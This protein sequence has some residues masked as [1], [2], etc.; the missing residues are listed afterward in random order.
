MQAEKYRPLRIPSL[1]VV[2]ALSARMSLRWS[3]KQM[4]VASSDRL[5]C[6]HEGPGASRKRVRA[7]SADD[8][9][10]DPPRAATEV[11]RL[12]CG[13][14]LPTRESR[15][16]RPPRSA[17]LCRPAAW[18]AFHLRRTAAEGGK[19]LRCLN[20]NEYLHRFT[21]QV[22]LVH[23]GIGHV[24]CSLIEFIIDGDSGSHRQT[25]RASIMMHLGIN[26]CIKKS[27]F[28]S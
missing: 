15:R 11:Y 27:G 10:A 6:V 5:G 24:Q 1:E 8:T 18:N 7:R 9:T 12:A 26:Y 23:C 20:A 4:S 14:V 21:K 22:G 17:A 28:P 2:L 25:S 13:N 19:P 3:L 16:V